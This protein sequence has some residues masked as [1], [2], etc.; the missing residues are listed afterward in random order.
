[1]RVVL[2]ELK[3]NPFRNFAVDPL[4]KE[5]VAKLKESISK[6]PAGFWG[7]IVA[8]KHNGSIEL[9]FG[10]HRIE[11][12]KSAGIHAE[13]IKVVT[14]ISDAEMIRMYAGEN[15]TQRG[16]QGTAITGTVASAAKYKLKEIFLG[17]HVRGNP[18]T[19]KKALETIQGQVAT[20]KGIGRDIIVEFL[21]NIPGI[22]ENVVKQQ[23]IN[24]KTSGHYDK[25]VGEVKN[26]IEEE[27]R[28]ADRKEEKRIA[29]LA[30]AAAA[31]EEA[32]SF[33]RERIFDF[34]GVAKHIKIPSHLDV[35]REIATGP[36]LKTVRGDGTELLLLPVD[37]QADLAKR[38][39]EYA[40]EH[41][42]ELSGRFIRENMISMVLDAKGTQR[43]LS[44]KE[45]AELLRKDWSAQAKAH[46]EQF[47]RQARGMLAAALALSDHAKKRPHGVTLHMTGEFRDAVDK[48]DKAIDLLRKAKI[49]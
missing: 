36:G 47:A 32:A 28:E 48:A 33:K 3:P 7:G 34:E 46:Q 15:A 2:S 26:E 12:A 25:I 45:R 39:V 11:A 16:N 10:H 30:K 49:V 43:R 1:M 29:E 35:F 4:D 31:A 17:D 13:D 6:N 41:E 40:A 8:R 37:R 22:N 23:L 20:Q 9:A 24:L 19:S 38:L 44:A 21:H 42:E 14:D 5:V 18:Q 27:L